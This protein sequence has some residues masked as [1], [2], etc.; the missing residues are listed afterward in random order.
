MSLLRTWLSMHLR[1]RANPS[2]Y[3]FLPL[4]SR[5]EGGVGKASYLSWRN[6]QKCL[7]ADI[8][9]TFRQYKNYLFFSLYQ[10]GVEVTSATEGLC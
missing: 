4:P 9:V 1:A 7:S 6:S 2:F 3:Q 10:K 5:S 8:Y